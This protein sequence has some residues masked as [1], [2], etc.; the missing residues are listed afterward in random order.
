MVTPPG[1]AGLFR[2][3]V[4]VTVPVSS[5]AALLSALV[6]RVNVVGAGFSA[7]VTR[8]CSAP[9]GS[10]AHVHDDGVFAA[11]ERNLSAMLQPVS[12]AESSVPD[13]V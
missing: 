2:V 1:P 13:V 7:P 8:I 9:A 5:D 12:E 10:A 4:T 3:A 6:V 11:H